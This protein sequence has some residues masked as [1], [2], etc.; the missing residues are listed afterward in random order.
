[1]H[2]RASRTKF[3]FIKLDFLLVDGIEE[4]WLDWLAEAQDEDNPKVIIWFVPSKYISDEKNGPFCSHRRKFMRHRGYTMRSWHMCADQY[5]SAIRQ[6]RAAVIYFKAPE[7]KAGGPIM[8]SASTMPA[9]SMSNMLLPTGI[10]RMAWNTKRSERPCDLTTQK[11]QH[12]CKV[13]H[14]LTDGKFYKRNGPMPDAVNV[15]IRSER[16]VRRLLTGEVAKPSQ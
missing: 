9:R 7:S 6:D 8:P 4:E 14:Q 2:N 13:S 3:G 5:G 12:P 10:P 15:W 11:R 16:G 1:M